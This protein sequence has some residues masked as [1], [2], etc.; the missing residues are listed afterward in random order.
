MNNNFVWGV[1]TAAYQVEGAWL[2]DG[3]GLSIWDA[4]THIPCKIS[5]ND[6]G[7][8]ACDQYHRYAEDVALMR[9]LGVNAYRFSLSWSRIIPDGSGQV[10]PAG[11]AYYNRLIDCLLENGITPWVTLYH[12]DLPLALQMEDD[13]WLN[14]KTAKNFSRYAKICFDN[15]GDRVKNWIT[16]NEPWCSAVL[17]HGL[18]VFAPGRCS[19]DEPYQAGHHLLLGHA[20]AVREF[21]NGGFTGKIG[22]S[23]NC[24]WREPLTE[25]QEDR[26]AA[27]RALEFFYGWFTD[28]PVKGDYPDV[29]RE[30]L[31]NRLPQFTEEEKN[32]LRASVDFLGLNHYTTAFASAT[33]T[34]DQIDNISGN[35]GMSEE[36]EVYLSDSPEWEKTALQWNVVPWGFR[37]MLNW[38]G[39]RY[40]SL[41][42]YVTE[43]GC[44]TNDSSREIA[45]NDESR[46][47]FLSAYID[48]MQQAVD[49]DGQNVQGYFCWSLLDNFEWVHGYSQ[50]FGLIHCDFETLERTPKKS[51]YLFQN[52]IK[53]QTPIQFSNLADNAR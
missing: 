38:I 13:G 26:L 34:G 19:P 23:N 53:K 33:P 48:A 10:N 3:K 1:A 44:T 22:I 32:M 14:R 4:F 39:D 47:R 20:M 18:A 40:P 11:I 6:T 52:I 36:Q 37:K 51:Y 28:P 24:D 50:R 16:L 17:G 12:W 9:E 45:E 8:I 35:G 27:Q 30:R 2:E 46:C 5:H 25:T 43:N 7:D 15:F 41:P 31:G 21:R 29:M 42:I 49:A